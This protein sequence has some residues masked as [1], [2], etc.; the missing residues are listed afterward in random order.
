[1][2]KILKNI[3]GGL[4]LL[5]ILIVF[6]LLTFQMS[7]KRLIIK[8]STYV[9]SIGDLGSNKVNAYYELYEK[10]SKTNS[11]ELKQYTKYIKGIDYISF[12]ETPTDK[13]KE[14]GEVLAINVGLSYPIAKFKQ[15]QYFDALG[16]NYFSL[17]DKYQKELYDKYSIEEKIYMT[18]YKGYFFIS[19]DVM[20]LSDYMRLLVKKETNKNIV[21]KLT[22]KALGELVYDASTL[23]E[24]IT[25]LKLDLD[26]I[27]NELTLN[28]SLYGDIEFSSVFEGI[29]S[30][31]R[32]LEKYMGKD[33]IYLTNKDFRGLTEFVRKRI[34][35]DMNSAL[36]LVKMFTG[37]DLETYMDKIDG[38]LIYDYTANQLIVLVKDT[39][40][41]KELLSVFSKKENGNYVLSNGEV[42]EIDGNVI[43]YNGKMLEGDIVP[44]KDEFVSGSINLGLYNPKFQ[45]IYI[46]A[47][48]K[49]YK[50]KIKIR[51]ALKEEDLLEIYNKL[52]EE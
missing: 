16:K 30:K 32:K 37:K 29:D 42:I 7:E 8:E 47:G 36:S 9:V 33:K 4:V 49:I 27:D 21:S 3:V 17:K 2:N 25:A 46:N 15:S 19:N 24:G 40:D 5:V 23:D 48:G 6:Y 50:D 52:E 35:P 13:L 11:K 45:D 44:K 28:G 18:N 38:E 41:L 22:G 43:Y 12:N 26:Y 34:N 20:K 39:K 10:I 1:M 31:K 14:D 51:V